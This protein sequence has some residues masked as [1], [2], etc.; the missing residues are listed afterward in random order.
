MSSSRRIKRGTEEDDEKTEL[1]REA[2]RSPRS[3]DTVSR[4]QVKFGWIN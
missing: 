4:S 3:Q 2:R 1:G